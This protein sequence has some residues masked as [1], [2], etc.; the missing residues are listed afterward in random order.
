MKNK[1]W[2]IIGC[3]VLI[4]LLVAGFCFSLYQRGKVITEPIYE[5]ENV[6]PEEEEKQVYTV[7]FD[8]NGGESVSPLKVFNGGKVVKPEDPKRDGYIFVSWM[9]NDEEFDFN[10]IISENITLKATWEKEQVKETTSENKTVSSTS[11]SST[12]TSSKSSSTIDKINLNDYISVTIHYENYAQ[13]GGYYFITNLEEIF[14]ELAGKKKLTIGWNEDKD[15]DGIDL[16]LDDFLDAVKNK[17]TFDSEKENKAKAVVQKIEK[18]KKK[19][20]KFTSVIDGHGIDYKYEYLRISNT[21]YHEINDEL[22]ASEKSIDSEIGNTFKGAIYVTL[23]GYGVYSPYD[24][25]LTKEIC[26]EYSLTC[27]KW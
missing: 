20:I 23:P 18:E 16:G 19:G 10:T 27:D 6:K 22:K 21:A 25:L 1:K 15:D 9:Y 13:P 7:L 14:P 17:F 11:S 3:V 26:E 12:N 8:S 2:I 5:I 24:K 4:G